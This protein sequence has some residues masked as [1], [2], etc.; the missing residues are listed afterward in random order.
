MVQILPIMKQR[1]SSLRYFSLMAAVVA[2]M[3]ACGGHNHESH[4]DH[5]H[6]HEVGHVHG[7]EKDADHDHEDHDGHDHDG[8]DHASGKDDLSESHSEDD[9]HGEKHDSD[10]IIL[11]PEKAKAAGVEVETVATDDFSSVIKTGGKVL[12]ASGDESTIVAPAA[13]IVSM[14]RGFT[15]GMAVSKGAPVLSLSSAKLPEG[16]LTKR[17]EL[18]FTQA[19]EDFERAEKLRADKLI[20]EKEYLAAKTDYE[21]ARLAYEATGGKPSQSGI[22]VMAPTGG[23]VKECMVNDGDYVEVGQPLMRL[24]QNRKLYLRAE[25]PQ[26]FYDKIANVKSARFRPSYTDR[27]YDISELDGRLVASGQSASGSF[28]PVTFEFNNTGGVV[29]GSFA[30]IYLISGNRENVISIPVSALT[31]EQGVKFVY[32]QV[33]EE[34]YLKKEVKTGASDGKR[35]EILSGLTPGDRLVTKGAIHVKLASASAAI[36]AHNHNH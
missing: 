32:V 20:T 16:E 17:N 4:D 26:R 21:R 2:M 23:Y 1:F 15:D 24:T 27:V 13:G 29:P 36:P 35:V 14:K 5:D 18:G 22:T 9:D 31:E 8:H 19:K 7:T 28:I 34:G 30:E 3:T 25:V 12:T 6:D 11:S 33:D 10:E